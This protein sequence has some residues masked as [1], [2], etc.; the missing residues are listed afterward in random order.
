MNIMLLKT[1]FSIIVGTFVFP[2][3]ASKAE[4]FQCVGEACL[5][6]PSGMSTEIQ[7]RYGARNA[8]A[9]MPLAD[10]PRTFCVGDGESISLLFLYQGDAPLNKSQ[11]GRIGIT[12]ENV[13]HDLSKSKSEMG[14]LLSS[15]AS[16]LLGISKNEIQ[17]IFGDPAHVVDS[18]AR[19]TRDKRYEKTTQSSRFGSVCWIYDTGREDSLLVN[20]FCFDSMGKVRTIWLTDMP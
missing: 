19:E 12:R 4:L 17:N 2:A 16:K 18:V 10:R 1:I 8:P 3:Q 6:K 15:G 11:L 7:R 9:K 14:S 13:C 20:E 5:N